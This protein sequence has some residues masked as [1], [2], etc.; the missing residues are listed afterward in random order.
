MGG[1]AWAA[2]APMQ[3]D[4]SR[5]RTASQKDDTE[6]LIYGS[7]QIYYGVSLP[8]GWITW[9][10]TPSSVALRLLKE[11]AERMEPNLFLPDRPSGK[12]PRPLPL[13]A[14][15]EA[16]TECAMGPHRC[17]PAT[18]NHRMEASLFRSHGAI[19]G[20]LA[21]HNCSESSVS[22]SISQKLVLLEAPPPHLQLQYALF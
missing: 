5:G 19:P 13:G 22:V 10:F 21:P 16:H 4:P 11:A 12:G 18:F 3:T 9:L 8:P 14:G 6:G 2:W 20:S 1:A 15:S 17:F 7:I